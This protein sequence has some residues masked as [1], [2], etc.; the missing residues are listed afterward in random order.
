MIAK[1]FRL[2]S[3][4]A[5]QVVPPVSALPAG[6]VIPPG[7]YTVNGVTYD[8]SQEGLYRFWEPL[9]STQHR[10]VYSSDV[11]ALMSAMAWLTVNGR[12]DEPLSLSALT[13]AALNYHLRLLCGKTIEWARA[14]C[15]SLGLQTRMCRA[16]TAGAPNNYFDG[17]VMLEVKVGGVW[18]LYDIAN[19]C[20]YGASIPLKDAVP[21]VAATVMNELA[22]DVYA[23][24][25]FTGAV[26]DV[27]SWRLNTMRGS[28]RRSEIERVLQIPGIDHTDGL[29]YFYMPAGTES[30]QAWV[31]GLSANYRVITQ[32][33]WT[34]QFYG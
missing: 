18:R 28:G 23:A 14:I 8:C 31:L 21:L 15:A 6:L 17:H 22:D 19:D 10:I 11:D 25:T 26:L 7:S 32:A 4:N 24:E 20:T 16:L 2:S 33:A 27:P 9:S 34:A 29:T 3:D 1:R 30:R 5:V 12:S 13:N